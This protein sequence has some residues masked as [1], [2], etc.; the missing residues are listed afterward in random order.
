VND[1][2]QAARERA[3]CPIADNLRAIFTALD[4]ALGRD[5]GDET[6]QIMGTNNADVGDFAGRA[7]RTAARICSAANLKCRLLGQAQRR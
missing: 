1:V 6:V 2:G 3:P 5:P 7:R 4:E